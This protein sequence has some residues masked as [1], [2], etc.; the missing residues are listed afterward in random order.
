MERKR[1]GYPVDVFFL[2]SSKRFAHCVDRI[3]IHFAQLFSGLVTEMRQQN[4]QC[5]NKR[6]SEKECEK[7]WPHILLCFEA[8][9]KK[10]KLH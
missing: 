5:S 2:D 4:A 3:F 8:F 10:E 6:L 9:P 7:S 1:S